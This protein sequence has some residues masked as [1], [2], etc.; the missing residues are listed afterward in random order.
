MPAQASAFLGHTSLACEVNRVPG[1]AV[2]KRVWIAAPLQ[3]Q[4]QEMEE[5]WGG[6]VG[7]QITGLPVV[8][9]SPSLQVGERYSNAGLLRTHFRLKHIYYFV[10]RL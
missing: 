10:R 5:E 1:R 7:R 3:I 4:S 9:S 6:P 8:H 2:C